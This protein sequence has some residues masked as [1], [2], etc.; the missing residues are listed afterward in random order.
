MKCF[1]SLKNNIN[2]RMSPGAN[3]LSALRFNILDELKVEISNLY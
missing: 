1:F 2:F 3:L